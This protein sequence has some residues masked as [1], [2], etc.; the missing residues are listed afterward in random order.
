MPLHP[1]GRKSTS[2]TVPNG[3]QPTESTCQAIIMVAPQKSSEYMAGPLPGK[4]TNRLFVTDCQAVSLPVSD[5][6]FHRPYGH[7]GKGFQAM[8]PN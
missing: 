8:P 2:K 1:P 3:S 5:G 4:I 7:K 6:P